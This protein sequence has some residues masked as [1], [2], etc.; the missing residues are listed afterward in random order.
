MPGNGQEKKLDR[1]SG[2][3]KELF[4]GEQENAQAKRQ[5]ELENEM[6]GHK[7]GAPEKT[8]DHLGIHQ[9][10]VL[11]CII[12]AP[13]CLRTRP[14]LIFPPLRAIIS[15]VLNIGGNYALNINRE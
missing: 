13:T 3:E 15:S 14:D 9:G 8:A 7:K 12:C 1:R 11:P 5:M 4:P 10:A 2:D 6:H